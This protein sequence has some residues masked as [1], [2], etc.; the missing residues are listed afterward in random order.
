[1]KLIY[2]KHIQYEQY[3]KLN[4]I[5]T[6]NFQGVRLTWDTFWKYQ[7]YYIFCL[8]VHDFFRKLYNININICCRVLLAQIKH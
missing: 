7:I 2:T 4:N 3:I 6:I 8:D 1:M 5:S